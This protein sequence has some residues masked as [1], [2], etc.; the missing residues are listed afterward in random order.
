M[1]VSEPFIRR[2][3][4]TFL[5]MAALLVGGIIGYNLLP[6]A[7]LPNIDFPTI[8][9]T[10]SLPGAS[11]E[12]M[13]A[14]V[15]QPLERQF[16]TLRGIS[17]ITS[18]NIQGVSSITLQFDLSRNIDGA[19][20]DVQAAINAASGLLPK[21]LPNPPTFKKVNPAESPVFI[22]GVT[23]DTMTLQQMDQY[24]DLNLAQR[25]SLLPGISQVV[26]FGE[27]KYAPT[28]QLNPAAL[29]ARGIGVDDVA[30]AI[31]GSTVE[32]PVGALQG[33]RQAYQIGANGQLFQ[34]DELSR[35]IV[36]YRNGAP[37]RIGDLGRVVVGSDVPLQLDLV[38]NHVGEMIGIWRQQGSNT[39]DVVE[40]VK[41]ML[42]TLQTGMPPSIKL[43]TVSDR[44]VSIS[45]SFADVKL[46]LMFTVTLVV[47]VIFVFLRSFWATVIPSITVPLSLF[48]TLPILYVLGD[49][50]DNLSLMGLTLAVGLV[51]DD[52]IVMLENIYR[53][54]EQ[55]D[56]PLTAA[57]KGAGEIGFTIMSITISLIAVFIPVLFMGGIVGRLFR[58]F[59]VTVSVAIV[60]SAI[61][62]LTLSPTMA[63]LFLVDPR[64]A[65]HGR[66]YQWSQRAF[67]RI[68]EGY[69]WALR[70]V[71]RIRLAAMLF[72]LSLIALSGLLLVTIPKGFIPDEDTGIVFGFTQASPDT[73]FLGMAELQQRAAAVVSSDPDVVTVGAAIGGGS[74]SGNNTGRLYVTLKPWNVRK[75]TEAQVIERLRPRL[76]Q[77]PGIKTYL[78]PLETI[79]VGGR[80]TAT[81]YQYT[82]QDNDLAELQQWAP[83][84]EDKL[85]TIPGIED[86]A[87]DLQ[88]ASAQLRI[89]I[90]RDLA[91][92]VGV[93]PT[94]VETALYDAFGQRYVTQLY[95]ALNTYHVVMEL[96]PQYQNDTS[97]LSRIYVHGTGGKLVPVS[98]FA[99][100]VPATTAVSVNHQGQFPAV[101]LSFN[102]AAGT[103]IGQAVD[104][105]ER[106]AAEMGMPRTVQTSFQGTAQA[107]QSSL[108]TEPYLI[109]A[110][111]FAV[112]IVLGVLYESLVH[113]VTILMSL[114][115]A[116][117]GAL[118]TLHLFGF[119]LSIIAIIGLVML[120]GI[121]KKNAIMM[122]DFA[123]ERRRHGHRSAE[124]AIFEAAVLRFR[125][126][127]M[128]TMA[129]IFGILPIALGLGA[130][131]SLRQP[132]GVA[133]VGG[134]VVSQALTLF[135]IPVT[136]IYMDHLSDWFGRLGRRRPRT[137]ET[138]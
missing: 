127:M 37:V 50:L 122:I 80:L 82:L 33:R 58:E 29:A 48:G 28:V 18:T 35:V 62:A 2:P 85:K 108:V 19:G 49:S 132:L 68:V 61:I 118:L 120:I 113:P 112:Y 92:R 23:S 106:A 24:V 53:Y 43:I 99:R 30:T 40:G 57:L 84:V 126:I 38:N 39:L 42:P 100:L 13:A 131:S 70:G 7:A 64:R 95:G 69:Q 119:D 81:Q 66:L 52:A 67:D 109:A 60:L 130:G 93:D 128:T 121:V 105:I 6:V 129:A 59:G 8:S 11:P 123:I 136:Y 41:R 72:N 133:V 71:L 15:A 76:A 32:Q 47:L 91:S 110:A 89:D 88:L 117:V 96:E 36:V 94:A 101:T 125:P 26:I 77:V 16:A 22:L 31:A 45:A 98:Q 14:S 90:N 10:A 65:S 55:G 83:R 115:P 79:R 111:I 135:T 134:L 3:I 51:V 97:A 74:S 78:Q 103:S 34:T 87:S 116:G 54:L 56:D 73:S 21:Q 25:I 124:E 63:A 75:A 138:G 107:F 44:S 104:R 46:T 17:Q 12:I 27:Q 137:A 20:S 114:P 1:N 5:L 86:V 102:L 4:A 9:V